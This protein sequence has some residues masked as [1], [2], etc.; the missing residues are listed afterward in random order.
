MPI[1]CCCYRKWRRPSRLC[2][3]QAQSQRYDRQCTFE[4]GDCRL[5]LLPVPDRTPPGI[6]DASAHQAGEVPIITSVGRRSDCKA[7]VGAQV[8]S[9]ALGDERPGLCALLGADAAVYGHQGDIAVTLHTCAAVGAHALLGLAICRTSAISLVLRF[10]HHLAALSRRLCG[11]V[12]K[13][14]SP[15]NVVALDLS[16]QRCCFS[17]ETLR[18][19]LPWSASRIA[20]TISDASRTLQDVTDPPACNASDT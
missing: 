13:H 18:R 20:V 17:M 19:F 8:V 12:A 6:D 4:C 9:T 16:L 11:L 1:S 7:C 14:L 15:E 5:F 10:S 3:E 2:S